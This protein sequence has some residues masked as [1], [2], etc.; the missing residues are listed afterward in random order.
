RQNDRGCATVID[1]G[2]VRSIDL[3]RI[4]TAAVKLLQLLVREVFDHLQQLG[5][6]AEKVFADVGSAFDDIFLVLPVND[7]SHAMD[8]LAIAV[9]SQ[10][11]VPVAPPD[12]LDDV[13]S[14]TAEPRLQFLNN[15][16]VS[17]NGTIQAL[18]VAVDDEDQIVQL[19]ADRQIDGP[20]RFRLIGLTV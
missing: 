5:I 17:T 14:R 4:V 15:L 9:G 20:Q 8:E 18:Q 16:P 2:L 3:F 10:E 1:G 6:F 7:L 13:P 12:H 19:L 11:R